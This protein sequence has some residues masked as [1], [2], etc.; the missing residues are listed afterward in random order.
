MKKN[1]VLFLTVLLAMVWLSGCALYGNKAQY[2]KGNWY[3]LTG[4]AEV[5]RIEQDKLALEKLKAQPVQTASIKGVQTGY[6]GKIANFERYD[7]V[8]FILKGPETKGWLLLPGQ[9]KE[10]YLLPGKYTAEAYIGGHK[11]DGPKPFTVSV[12]THN[13]LGEE[14]HWFVFYEY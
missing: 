14:L 10:Y 2:D 8:N 4:S 1:I 12:Q 7:K 3:W 6:R 11:V 13:F 9:T 5:A